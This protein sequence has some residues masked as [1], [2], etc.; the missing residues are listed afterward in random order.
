MFAK[1]PYLYQPLVEGVTATV[2]VKLKTE[3]RKNNLD[4]L[5]TASWGVY[6]PCIWTTGS[7]N[8]DI[9][10][11][12]L[13]NVHMQLIP[14]VMDHFSPETQLKRL[15]LPAHLKDLAMHA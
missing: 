14:A 2:C 7:P 6:C 3:G 5:N 12:R 4:C 9:F 11:I 13:G 15:S 10:Y 1:V 8:K